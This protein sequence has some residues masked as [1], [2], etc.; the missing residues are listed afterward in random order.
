MSCNLPHLKAEVPLLEYLQRLNWTARPV[1]CRQEY[2]GICPLHDD[3]RPSFY[4]N[5]RKNVFY[6]HGCGQGG[7]LIRF[8]ELYFHLSFLES[9]AHL[10]RELGWPD[11]GEDDLFEDTAVF[12]QDQFP[13]HAD[14]VEYIHGRGVHDV[15]ILRA[16]RI[17]YA[18]GGMLRGH[19]MRLGYTWE[20]LAGCGLINSRG[21]DTFY[22]RIV[23]PCFDLPGAKNIYGRS[24]GD[25][26][27]HRFLCRSKGGLFAW[28]KVSGFDSVILVE[29]VF[30]V[31]V[32][33]QAGFRCTTC[34]FGTHLTR[35]HIAQLSDRP[36]RKVFI[37]FDCDFNG[38]GQAAARDVGRKL[39][40]A[41]LQAYLVTLPEG[42]DPNSF[43]LAGATAQEWGR[44]LEQA[45]VV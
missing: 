1:G 35:A 42:Q 18:P 21:Q 6:C 36:G 2:V 19:L 24:I 15:E 13:L 30:D 32:L 40:E 39:N 11:L 17:G 10:R 29:G 43:V 5:V 4:V 9:V 41:G 38:A 8:V 23:F 28:S 20:L 14:A 16:L 45:E 33:W 22:R 44:R 7:D 26:A 25:S 34:A 37:A 3:S 27:P 12:Y 31:A